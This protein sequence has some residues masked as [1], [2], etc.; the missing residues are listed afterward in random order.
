QVL[1]AGDFSA[2]DARPRSRMAR[3]FPDGSLDVSFDPGL[4]PDNAVFSMILQPDGKPLIGGPFRSYNSTRRM[5]LARL[6]P[7]GSLDT[8]F[9]DTA[10]NQFA[11]L[12]NEFSFQPP[13]FINSMALQADGNLIIGG[14]FTTVGGNPSANARLRNSWTVFTRADKRTRYNI[15]R[16][17]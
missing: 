6:R 9:M 7:D 3:L 1:I 4:G 8:T 15:A 12:I 17:L 5:G 14:S 10:Y 11:G 16:I 13:N 2:I